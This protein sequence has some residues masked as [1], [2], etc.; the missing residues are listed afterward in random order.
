MIGVDDVV[1]FV[2]ELSEF[3]PLPQYKYGFFRIGSDISV[4]SGLLL[5][6]GIFE[7]LIDEDSMSMG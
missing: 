5:V 1:V 4:G 2:L 7:F 3:A 6:L